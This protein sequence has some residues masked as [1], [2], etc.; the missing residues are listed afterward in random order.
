MK[1]RSA[2]GKNQTGRARRINELAGNSGN[3]IPGDGGLSCGGSKLPSSVASGAAHTYCIRGN[4]TAVLYLPTSLLYKSGP[5][6]SSHAEKIF[7]LSVQTLPKC[8]LLPSNDTNSFNSFSSPPYWYL[9]GKQTEYVILSA[10]AT[11][12]RDSLDDDILQTSLTPIC[13]RGCAKSRFLLCD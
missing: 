5:W 1:K 3:G 11:S 2:R 9:P 13:A 8:V 6:E 7:V 4:Y 10:I 12:V